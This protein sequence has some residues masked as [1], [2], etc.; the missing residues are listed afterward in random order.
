MI[1]L[2]AKCNGFIEASHLNQFG[3]KEMVANEVLAKRRVEWGFKILG[4]FVGTD[5]YVLAS[6]RPKNLEK[7]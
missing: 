5:E 3:I 7:I 2:I 4:A 1:G 6:L